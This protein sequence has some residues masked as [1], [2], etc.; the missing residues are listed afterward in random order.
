[1]WL[2]DKGAL[3][4]CVTKRVTTIIVLLIVWQNS[5][6][7]QRLVISGAMELSLWIR[8]NITVGTIL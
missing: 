2:V 5:G 4:L 7:K 3:A 6:I 8:C 1:M